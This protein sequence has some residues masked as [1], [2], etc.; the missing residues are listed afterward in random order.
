MSTAQLARRLGM[1]QPSVIAMEKSEAKGTIQMST[2]RKAAA[3][4][5]CVVVYALVPRRPLEVTVRSRARAL[6]MERKE[7]VAHSMALEGQATRRRGGE[8]RV[9]EF[10]RVTDPARLWDEP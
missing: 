2:L 1:K 3:A 8:A 10:L 4:M 6:L 7:A 5:D 9:S